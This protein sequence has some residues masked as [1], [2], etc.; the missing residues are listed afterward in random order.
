MN[1]VVTERG[2]G[3]QDALL[4]PGE[5]G[6]AIVINL[7]G[8]GDVGAMVGL[9]LVVAIEVASRRRVHEADADKRMMKPTVSTGVAMAQSPKK[10]EA[11]L[12]VR[13]FSEQGSA[14][15]VFSLNFS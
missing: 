5:A 10:L 4:R 11:H 13:H 7:M 1:P 14:T 8:I 12:S 15:E 6:A 9:P 2:R 3:K